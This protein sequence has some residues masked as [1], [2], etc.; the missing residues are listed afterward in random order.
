VPRNEQPAA[1][2]AAG[3]TQGGAP[4]PGRLFPLAV[5]AALVVL[6]IGY[7]YAIGT[8]LGPGEGTASG[9]LWNPLDNYSYAAWA[10]QAKRGAWTFSDLYTTDRHQ[11]LLFNAYFL[12]VGR[13]AAWADLPVITVMN[14]LGV[15]AAGATVVLVYHVAVAI[16]FSRAAARWAAVFAAFSSGTAAFAAAANRFLGTSL[17]L[18]H[19]QD[20]VLFSTFL[21]YPYQSFSAGLLSLAILL[22]V[23]AQDGRASG[24][25]LGLCLGLLAPTA[26]MLAFTHPYEPTMLIATFLVYA[27]FTLASPGAP[28]ARRRLLAV[29]AVLLAA[30]LP[31]IA[32]QLWLSTQPVW[33]SFARASL[34]TPS[35]RAN[36]L[37]VYGLALPLALVGGWVA[38][39][40]RK[41]WRGRWLLAWVAALVVLLMGVA[42]NQAKACSGGYV[43]MSVL[44][45]AGWAWL[46]GRA[47]RVRSRPARRASYALCAAAGVCAFVTSAYLLARQYRNFEYDVPLARAAAKVH[48]LSARRHP[49]VIC[50]PWVGYQLPGTAGLRVYCGHWALTPRYAGRL[51]RLLDCGFR[52][53]QEGAPGT[54]EEKTEALRSL[55]AASDAEFVILH[56]QA[57]AVERMPDVAGARFVGAFGKWRLY[58]FRRARAAPRP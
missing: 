5:A 29:L 46:L 18:P 41:L 3:P 15:A 20:A 48:E 11:P 49:A 28:V 21:A 7:R 47:R 39:R 14:V 33:D 4:P 52:R 13:L 53:R 1:A 26:L 6:A 36:W 42:V 24:R 45:A 22:A 57:P 23:A 44:A 38:L 51:Q 32:Y 56:R 2:P 55:L 58:R 19:Y 43:A 27:A 25:K 9:V 35:P 16:G 50:D 10:Q 30:T 34:A 54:P 31:A 12:L 17:P 40:S 37:G 8:R